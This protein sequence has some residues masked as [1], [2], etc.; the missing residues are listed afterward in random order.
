[1]ILLITGLGI[2]PRLFLVDNIRA[3]AALAARLFEIRQLRKRLAVAGRFIARLLLLKNAGLLGS[4]GPFRRLTATRRI[5]RLPLVIAR[6][7]AR[8]FT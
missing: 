4:I 5:L 3:I 2:C 1:M 8:R 7:N 6:L